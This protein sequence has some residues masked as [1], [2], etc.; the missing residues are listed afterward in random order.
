M[1][2]TTDSGDLRYVEQIR[3]HQG[4]VGAG[5]LRLGYISL[6]AFYK[7]AQRTAISSYGEYLMSVY[8]S[9]AS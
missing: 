1:V 6:D 2:V 9:F 5:A 3:L 7:L 4:S 8:Q